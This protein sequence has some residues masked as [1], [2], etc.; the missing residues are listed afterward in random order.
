L[1]WVETDGSGLNDDRVSL[2]T[3]ETDVPT[4]ELASLI[5]PCLVL[6]EDKALRRPGYAPQ[7]WRLAAG[8]GADVVEGAAD[9]QAAAMVVGLPAVAILGGSIRLGNA[10]RLP[11]WSSLIILAIGGYAVLRKPGRRASLG[12][13]VWP[14]VEVMGEAMTEAAAREE[15]GIHG[16]RKVMFMPSTSTTLKRQIAVVLA[17]TREPL[18]ALEVVELVEQHFDKIWSVAEVRGVLASSPEFTQPERH[19]WQLG[20]RS[21]SAPVHA[22]SGGLLARGVGS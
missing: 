9:R 11:S 18:L 4:A 15:A 5:A 19:R 7:A 17:R 1:R 12:K 3:D 16:M 2:V 13:A 20:R 21:G 6:S 8:H 22:P 10:V 14:C